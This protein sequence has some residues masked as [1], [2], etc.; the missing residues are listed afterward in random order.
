MRAI[1]LS[2]CLGLAL[3]APVTVA[4]QGAPIHRDGFNKIPQNILDG[5]DALRRD[6]PGD[7]ET[8]WLKDSRFPA[9]GS[10]GNALQNFRAHDGEYQGFELVATQDITQ[11]MRVIYLVLNYERQP[12]FVKFTAYRTDKEWVVLQLDLNLDVAAMEAA[13]ANMPHN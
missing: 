9:D 12:H 1:A 13:L 5:L 2:L 7:T 6:H 3:A 11:R 4:E 10:T 8:A